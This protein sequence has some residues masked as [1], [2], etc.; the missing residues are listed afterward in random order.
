MIVANDIA[1][2]VQKNIKMCG[3]LV[4]GLTHYIHKFAKKESVILFN[5]REIRFASSKKNGFYEK[6]N[7]TYGLEELYSLTKLKPD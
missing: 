1:F 3:L 5:V 7:A 4:D 6:R 2:I